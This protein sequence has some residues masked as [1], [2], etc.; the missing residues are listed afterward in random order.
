MPL[1]KLVDFRSQNQFVRHSLMDHGVPLLLIITGNHIHD[2]PDPANPFHSFSD[3]VNF[4][5][6]RFI[7]K[8]L[9]ILDLRQFHIAFPFKMRVHGVGY[10]PC[11]IHGKHIIL[12]HF[13][14]S[15]HGWLPLVF[16][17]VSHAPDK[18]TGAVAVTLHHGFHILLPFRLKIPAIQA[19]MPFIKAFLIH[20][21]AK[22]I[23]QIQELH[24]MGMV[25]GADGI[26]AHLL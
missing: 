10:R 13:Q 2:L 3:V 9:D 1:E 22:L 25:G 12:Q 19:P 14:N 15:Q 21:K 16:H 4:R 7:H 5:I 11:R 26:A 8:F 17:L 20:V 6:V 24:G 23:A 18:N